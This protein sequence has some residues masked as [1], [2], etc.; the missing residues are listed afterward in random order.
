MSGYEKMSERAYSIH[1]VVTFKIVDKRSFFSRIFDAI[2]VEYKNFES[3]ELNNPDFTVYLGNISPSNQDCY[4]LDDQYFIKKDYLFCKESSYKLAKWKLEISGFESANMI[5]CI[6]SNLIGNM[7]LSPIIDFLIQFKLNERGYSLVHASCVS[8]NNHAYLFPALS[9]GGKTTVAMHF[10]ENGFDFLGDNFVVLHDGEAL[11]FLSPLNI[12]TYNLTPI[13]K[14]N[15]GVGKM[16]ILALKHLLYKMTLGYAKIFTKINVRTVFPNAIVDK[17]IVD[18]VSILIPKEEVR[19]ENISKEEL[20]GHLAM[21]QKLESSSF[22]DYMLEYSY[23]FPDSKLATHWNR[24][25]ENLRK[26]IGEDIPI[27][28]IEVPQ[29]YDTNTF[30]RI[31]KVIEDEASA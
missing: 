3:E 24:Y 16:I 29:K 28:K 21:N 31:V 11:S 27:Y 10:V 5:I 12:F 19:I 8:R 2:E 30:E 7:F 20:I 22:L 9:G 14:S 1:D 4:I 25:K 15:L 23:M 17:S 18:S 26:N 6:S 13:I